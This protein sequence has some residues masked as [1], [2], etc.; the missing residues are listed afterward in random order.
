MLMVLTFTVTSV[1]AHFLFKPYPN[2]CSWGAGYLECCCGDY[3][4]GSAADMRHRQLRGAAEERIMR[5]GSEI[6][7]ADSSQQL[8]SLQ[9]R[10][11]GT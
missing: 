6:I 7:N 1:T 8:L 10:G 4:G 9:H 3:D 2:T 5:A 11:Y